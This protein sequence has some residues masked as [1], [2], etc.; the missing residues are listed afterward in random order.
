MATTFGND[1]SDTPSAGSI[2][3]YA[4]IT[5]VAVSGCSLVCPGDNG[6][7]QALLSLGA[8]VKGPAEA[9]VRCALYLT[10]GTLVVEGDSEVVINASEAAWR[11][12]TSFT[13]HNSYTTLTGGTTYHF[14]AT[15][16]TALS[17]LYG[18]T[19]SS[20]DSRYVTGDW[21]GG[22]TDPWPGT[23]SASTLRDHIRASVEPAGQF[24]RPSSDVAGGTFRSIVTTAPFGPRVIA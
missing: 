17:F 12:H 20:G 5:K 24:A 6:T 4:S 23:S 16:D 9:H 18:T 15:G 14:G 11:E 2:A 7:A 10:D 13:W 8:Y 1:V 21:T 22:F 19:G 3:S